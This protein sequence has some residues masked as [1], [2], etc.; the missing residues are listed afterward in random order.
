MFLLTRFDQAK[1]ENLYEILLQGVSANKDIRRLDI[2]MDQARC[3]SLG[4]RVTYLPE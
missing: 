4:Q 3:M 2:A 1:V